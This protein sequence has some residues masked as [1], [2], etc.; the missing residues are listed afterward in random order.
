MNHCGPKRG[1]GPGGNQT[2]KF[3]VGLGVTEFRPLMRVPF[4]SIRRGVAALAL[5]SPLLGACSSPS[6]PSFSSMFGSGTAAGDANATATAPL[7]LPND[8][9][10]PQVLI[11]AGA[12]TLTSNANPAD[13]TA[14][15]LRYQVGLNTTARECR[16]AAPN[17]LSIKVGIQGRAVLGPQGQ[18]GT[19][20]VPIRYAVVYDGVPA[21]TIT[22][23]LE[24]VQVTMSENDSNVL[25]SHVVEGLEFPMP[26]PSEIESYV[27]Y[28]GFDPVGA[29]QLERKKAPPPRPAKPK[30]PPQQG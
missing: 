21:R 20:D 2:S 4:R 22:T 18:P 25:F 24:R 3:G 26:K 23:K 15:S 12:G 8:F 6:M 29:Q 16:L 1:A 30:R 17:V 10:C 13:E 27:V 11:R 28:I 19:I 5:L 7:V 9:D 14:T